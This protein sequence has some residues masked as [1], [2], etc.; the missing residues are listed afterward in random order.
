[1]KI[2]KTKI[3]IIIILFISILLMQ[4]GIHFKVKIVHQNIIGNNYYSENKLKLNNNN[5]KIKVDEINIIREL[6][7]NKSFSKKSNKLIS[8]EEYDVMELGT[9][10]H[11]YLEFINLKNPNYEF[12]KVDVTN[13]TDLFNC[14]NFSY[15]NNPFNWGGN[16]RIF[17]LLSSKRYV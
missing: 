5:K 16:P 4:F 2:N 1:M 14:K 13:I 8:K 15:T 17:S 6:K 9:N 11:E 12:Y 10:I 3:S 7:E